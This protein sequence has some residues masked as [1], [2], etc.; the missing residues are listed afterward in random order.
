M[1]VASLT[2]V[3]TKVDVTYTTLGCVFFHSWDKEHPRA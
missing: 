3:W 1:G 2:T